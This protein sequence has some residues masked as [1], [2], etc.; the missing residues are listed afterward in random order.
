MKEIFLK[1]P[2]ERDIVFILGA[3]ASHPDGVPL[4]KDILPYILSGKNSEITDSVIGKE[5]IQFITENFDFDISLEN[6]P[7]LEAVFGYLDYFIYN[8]Q[9]LSSYYSQTKLQIIR[10]YLIKLV[11]HAVNLH[12]DKEHTAY[13]NFWKRV[14]YHTR[15]FSIITLNYDTLL[16]QAFEEYFKTTGFIDYSIPLMNYEKT[17]VL[18]NF[19]F[20][21]N[22][23][24]P[25]IVE[26]EVDPVPFKILKL[27]GSLNWKYCNCCNQ[28]LLTP[29]DRHIDLNKGKFL[30]Y[31]YPENERYE[32][33]CPIDNTDFQT[34]I[35]PPSYTKVMDQP[36]LT[37]LFSEAARELRV[38]RHLV[39]IGYSFS[40]SDVHIKAL[41]KKNYKKEINITVVNNR[42]NKKL[43]SKYAA[44]SKEIKFLEITMEEFISDNRYFNDIFN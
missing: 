1:Y 11:H 40:S 25:V 19:N 16:E 29:W 17:D 22:P 3:G 2:A 42:I 6:Y 13:H 33:S 12:T 35:Q 26:H 34:L 28:T 5:V 32:Y 38:A 44:I 31:T 43:K 37:Q 30:G 15:N 41:L 27:H 14:L 18:K 23:N 21:V 7:N 24:Q 10:E 36:V 20:W 9:S 4:K 39:F 8:N